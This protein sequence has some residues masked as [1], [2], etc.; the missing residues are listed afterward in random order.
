MNGGYRSAP[1]GRGGIRVKGACAMR[2]KA[3]VGRQRTVRL[4]ALLWDVSARCACRVCRV[5][6]A[7]GALAGPAAGGGS[8][9]NACRKQNAYQYAGDQKAENHTEDIH[10]SF[11]F[12]ILISY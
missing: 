11:S 3:A 9:V 2:R 12:A 6:S 4:P 7:H 5:E 1:L 10:N 8:G